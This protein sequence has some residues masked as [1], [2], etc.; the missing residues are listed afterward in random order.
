MDVHDEARAGV[1]GWRLFELDA[2][3]NPAVDWAG[4]ERM[5]QDPA[6]SEEEYRREVLGELIPIGDLVFHAWSSKYNVK[7]VPAGPEATAAFT[8]AYLGRAYSAIAVC[9]FQ[10]L[11]HMAGTIWRAY[12]GDDDQFLFWCVDTALVEK[13]DEDDLI[14][15]LEDRGLTGADTAVIGDA[16]GEWQDA[17]R[18]RGRGS[19]DVFRQRG[20]RRLY[21][22]DA[23]S[24]KNPDIIATVRVTNGLMRSATGRRRLFSTPENIHFH[25]AVSRWENRGGVPYKRSDYA[26]IGD[27]VRY[28]AWRFFPRRKSPGT[29]EIKTFKRPKSR[30]ELEVADWG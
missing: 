17:E 23:R 15:A 18:T 29:L 28:F 12:R 21:L 1:D 6:V 19:F 11:P 25:R 2:R 16:S 27:T 5:K 8:K 7:P 26:H 20:W 3:D 4:L 10:T 14:D 9:D 24:K 30:R 22:P 13:G